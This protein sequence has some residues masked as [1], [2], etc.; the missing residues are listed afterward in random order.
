MGWKISLSALALIVTAQAAAA[1]ATPCKPVLVAVLDM[2]RR[3]DGVPTVTLGVNGKPQN[4]L[5]GTAFMYSFLF[6]S[7]AD[8]AGIEQKSNNTG[9]LVSTSY[10]VVTKTATLDELT[11]G[12]AAANKVKMLIDPDAPDDNKGVAGTIGVNLLA[13]FGVDVDF[14]ANKIRLFTGCTKIGGYWSS[15]YGELDIDL[16]TLGVPAAQWKLEGQPVTVTF[17]LNS[18]ESVM[19]FGSANRVLDLTPASPGVA[20][21]KDSKSPAYEYRFREL[22]AEGITIKNPRVLLYGSPDDQ[23]CDGQQRFNPGR[24]STMGGPQ[25]CYGS[26]DLRLGVRELSKLHLFFDFPDRKLYFTAADAR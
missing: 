20:E 10:G 19:P 11:F 5:L 4:M 16:Q 13:N 1:E 26:G 22:S 6:K 14:A 21:I 24:F 8:A 3:A 2:V 25:R 15:A 23:I 17:A 9:M 12:K 18:L 7:Y